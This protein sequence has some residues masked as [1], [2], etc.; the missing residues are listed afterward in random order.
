MLEISQK[1]KERTIIWSS[2][3]TSGYT[4]KG[5][6]IFI[7]KKY[8][9]THVPCSII[10]SSQGKETTTGPSTN[11]WI[12]KMSYVCICMCMCVVYIHTHTHTKMEYSSALRKKSCHLWQ[13]GWTWRVLYLFCENKSEREWQTLSWNHLYLQSLKEK[14]KHRETRKK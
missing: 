6:E 4:L 14:V 7:S 12:K 8:L 10:H 1:V 9:Y 5:N 13:H 2:N 11:E 3:S